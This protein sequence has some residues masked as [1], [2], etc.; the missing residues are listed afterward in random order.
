MKN[1]VKKRCL[2]MNYGIVYFSPMESNGIN[3]MCLCSNCKTI[4][5]VTLDASV[6]DFNFDYNQIYLNG[7]KTAYKLN[8]PEGCPKCGANV[9]LSTNLNI[10]RAISR[11]DI[12]NNEEEIKITVKRTYVG[13]KVSK[14]VFPLLEEQ[15][16][17][18]PQKGLTARMSR[19]SFGNLEG[20]GKSDEIN[21]QEDSVLRFIKVFKG[22]SE[23][24][25]IEHGSIDRKEELVFDKKTEE[26]FYQGKKVKGFKYL[27]N[28]EK[29]SFPKFVIKEIEKYVHREENEEAYERFGIDKE[30]FT[31][32]EILLRK[33]YINQLPAISYLGDSVLIENLEKEQE[34]KIKACKTAAEVLQVFA[35]YLDTKY[36]EKI[37]D[38]LGNQ[39]R[40]NKEHLTAHY[41]LFMLEMI[42]EKELIE[43]LIDKSKDMQINFSFSPNLFVRDDFNDN[44]LFDGDASELEELMNGVYTLEDFRKEVRDILESEDYIDRDIHGT[45]YQKEHQQVNDILFYSYTFSSLVEHLKYLNE[46]ME[47]GIEKAEN[48]PNPYAKKQILKGVEMARKIK[49]TEIKCSTTKEFSELLIEISDLI[50]DEYVTFAYTE[51]DLSYEWKNDDWLFYLPK[52]TEEMKNFDRKNYKYTSLFGDE[53]IQGTEDL[54]VMVEKDGSYQAHFKIT[55][56]EKDLKEL[57]SSTEY[58]SLEEKELF[59]RIKQY[60]KEKNLQTNPCFTFGECDGYEF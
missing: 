52:S 7:V 3:K 1:T 26:L 33:N 49:N 4:F 17:K 50:S 15:F 55:P 5:E 43:S 39:Y 45:I 6:Y 9:F 35:P 53:L 46:L 20:M 54:M 28:T 56:K 57:E 2:K 34:E 10:S 44:L 32:Q 11:I 51:K 59:D 19:L 48:N 60:M 42:Q 58:Q 21:L 40:Y 18:R 25:K 8:Q 31:P 22:L 24:F 29:M 36:A 23:H 47:V 30:K 13:I 38:Q 16:E 37:I 12:T 41:S 14:E 27:Y